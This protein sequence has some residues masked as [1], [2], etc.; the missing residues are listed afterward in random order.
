MTHYP[1][2]LEMQ[3]GFKSSRSIQRYCN[4]LFE[5][6]QR[7][8]EMNPEDRYK[9]R[10]EQAKPIVDA[11]F[12]WLETFAVTGGSALSKAK[13]YAIGERKYLVEYLNNPF[14]ADQ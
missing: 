6:E 11:F 14:S 10:Q 4:K 12:E 3:K 13:A 2:K 7:C 9:Y 5:I 1:R 8:K